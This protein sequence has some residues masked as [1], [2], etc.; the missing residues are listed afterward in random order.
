MRTVWIIAVREYKRYFS[1]PAAYAIALFLLLIIGVLFNGSIQAALINSFSGAG[2]A[3][4]IQIILSP[5]VFLLLFASPAITMHLLAEEQRMGTIELML[6]APVKDWELVVGKWLGGFLFLVTL[7]VVTLVYPFILNNLVSPGID[8][9][10]LISGYLGVILFCSTIIAIGV[11]ISSIFSNTVAAFFVT[12]GVL[13]VLWIVSVFG[14][15]TGGN[16]LLT[17]L[18]LRSHFYD[19]FYVGVI[20]IRDIVYHVSMTALFL[21][22]GSAIVEMRRW[23]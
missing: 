17:Y 8:Q 1:T 11:A 10:L 3:P 4:G 21:F 12:L 23:R 22:L 13:V 2:G 18:D 16:P 20:D 15:S 6:T 9:G 19:T 14:Q 5:M 7:I